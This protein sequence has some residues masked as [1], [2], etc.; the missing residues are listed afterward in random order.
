MT[1][2]LFE[3]KWQYYGDCTGKCSGGSPCYCQVEPG[4]NHS[5]C[6]CSDPECFCHAR[7]R[8]EPPPQPDWKEIAVVR[9]IRFRQYLGKTGLQCLKP[10]DLT[11][12]EWRDL[13]RARGLE[14][15]PDEVAP[16]HF[17]NE[18]D[19]ETFDNLLDLIEEISNG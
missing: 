17:D 11:Y 14:K 13:Q 12:Q 1:D 9:G 7:E 18:L 10:K 5:M 8:Y 15:I 6:I 3:P 2:Q 16:G 19:L 4:S